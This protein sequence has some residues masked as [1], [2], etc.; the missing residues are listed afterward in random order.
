MCKFAHFLWEKYNKQL[1]NNC[2]VKIIEEYEYQKDVDAYD[3]H[4]AILRRD[5]GITCT[6]RHISHNKAQQRKHAEGSTVW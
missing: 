4:D 6:K 3:S 2:T 5:V 1:N